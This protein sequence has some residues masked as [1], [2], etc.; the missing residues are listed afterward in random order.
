MPYASFGSLV[1]SL[2]KPPYFQVIIVNLC[3]FVVIYVN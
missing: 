1:L 2:L 3:E